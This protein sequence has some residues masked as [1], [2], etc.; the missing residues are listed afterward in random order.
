MSRREGRT[1]LFVSHNMESILKFCSR[2]LLLNSGQIVTSGDVQKVLSTYREYKLPGSNVINLSNRPR[3]Q[4]FPC[5]VRLIQVKTSN[6]E[7]PWSLPFGQHVAFEVWLESR[8]I[9]ANIELAVGLFSVRGF[10]LASWTNRCAGVSLSLRAGLNIIRVE[11]ADII[12][13]PG[14]YFVG[15]GVLSGRGFEDYVSEAASFEIVVSERSA[16]INAQNFGGVVVPRVI[17]ST[18]DKQMSDR[19]PSAD[20]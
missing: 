1:V 4:G 13:L 17:V 3:P 9:V 15:I 6:K 18:I 2:G 8:S 16:E 20:A 12:L 14:Q 5:R 19:S 11:Y 10:E 7:G